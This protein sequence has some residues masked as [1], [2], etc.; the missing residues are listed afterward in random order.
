[1]SDKKGFLDLKND[2]IDKGLCT[3]CGTCKGVCP[4]HAI[5]LVGE[6]WEPELV[7]EC[8]TCNICY[9]AC[10]GKDIPLPAMEKM[11]FGRQRDENNEYEYWL[12]VFQKTVASYAMDEKVRSNAASGGMATAL[13]I[14][15]LQEKLVDGFIVA[16]M[17]EEQPWRTK[18]YLATTVDELLAA[19]QTK[20]ALVPVNAV[21]EELGRRSDIKSVGIVAMPCQ[22]HA[23]RKMALNQSSTKILKKIK[24]VLGLLCGAQFYF[25]GTEH[26]IKEWC[27]VE[28]LE[29]V[30]KLRYREG[31]WPGSFYVQTKDGR[32]SRFPQKEYKYHH[33]IPFYQRDRCMM[34]LDYAA[35]LADIS[36]GDIWKLA[37]G[38]EAG[39]N[40]ALIRTDIGQELVD[41]AVKKNY[42]HVQPLEEDMLLNGT[43]GVEMKKHGNSTRFAGRIKHGLPVPE[44]GYQPTGH[45][46]PFKKGTKPKHS[47]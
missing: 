17:S 1:V 39:W 35:D 18:P 3:S 8:T 30:A 5:D 45:L 24:F 16:G 47:D 14:C 12:G 33:L 19:Q 20:Y 10:P 42:L 21:F 25:K 23:I 27:G 22:V 4:Q 26:L 44:F 31:S 46:H 41:L 28:N 13:A 29:D 38:G 2:I 37:K 15:A 9:T 40:A 11:L 43:I 6:E 32:E 36:I 34:C 7:G